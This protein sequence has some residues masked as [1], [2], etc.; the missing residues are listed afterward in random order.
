MYDRPWMLKDA[1][2]PETTASMSVLCSRVREICSDIPL[3]VQI[4][5]AANKQAMAVAKAAGTYHMILFAASA[6]HMIYQKIYEHPSQIF[7]D[8][9]WFI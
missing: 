3:G 2:G 7:S 8:D 9:F 6:Y 4:L 1:V 5:S